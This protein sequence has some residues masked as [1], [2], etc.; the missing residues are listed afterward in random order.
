MTARI[1]MF[2]DKDKT[3]KQH[4]PEGHCKQNPVFLF[5]AVQI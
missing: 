5:Q 3:K 2:D 1:K 4:I